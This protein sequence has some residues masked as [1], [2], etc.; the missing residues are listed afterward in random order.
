MSSSATVV[1]RK[2]NGEREPFYPDKLYQS[3]VRSGADTQLADQITTR[4][5]DRVRD[6]D[7]TRDIYRQAFASLRKVER[8]MAARYSVKHALLELGPSGYPFEDYLAEIFRVLGYNTTTR[9]MV[10]GRCVE[11]ELDLIGVRGTERFGAEAKY[12]NNAGLKSDI[13]VAL[14]VQARFEDIAA[15]NTAH[16]YTVRR[17]ITNTKFTEQVE[18]Y[19]ACI[20][21]ELISWDYPDR[22]NLRELIE[23]TGV[24]PISC[25]TTLSTTHK[26]RLMEQ[27]VVLCR[28]L[29]A[30]PGVLAALGLPERTTSLVLEEVGRLCQD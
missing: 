5:A 13:K 21:I 9:V 3:L 15:G 23:T 19:A 6:G 22:G 18:L 8:P 2:A 29:R 26:R 14:Y 24:H 12:H 10:R 1:V 11:H 7:A 17:L 25:V 20:G 27:G 16:P 28:Q 4:I 30:N